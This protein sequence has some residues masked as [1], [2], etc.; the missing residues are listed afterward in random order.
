MITSFSYIL[1]NSGESTGDIPKRPKTQFTQANSS[2]QQRNDGQANNV[3]TK[4]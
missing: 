2:R 1:K 3:K 4:I